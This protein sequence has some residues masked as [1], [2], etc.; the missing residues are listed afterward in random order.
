[1]AMEALAH[2][3]SLVE[4]SYDALLDA[5]CA[6]ELRPGE[7]IGQDEIAERLGVSR[8]P[9]NSAIAM[10]K[11]QRFVVD[12]GRRGVVVAPVDPLLFKAI[13]QV[14]AALD[15]LATELATPRLDA[16]AIRRGR[17]IVARG[18]ALMLAGNAKGVLQA[19]IDFHT[20]IYELSGNPVILDTMRLNWLHLRRTMGEVLRFPGMTAQVWKQH[21]E[22]WNAMVRQN[23]VE[24]ADLMRDHVVQAVE[25]V[26]PP[27]AA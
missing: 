16:T 8:Q 9:V 19:D 6:G 10:L 14:R 2:S 7:R 1:M 18:Q 5:I 11:A 15:P 27:Q 25:R 12:T 4:R 20:L 21:G 17:S 26:G 23:A 22:I 13:Y 24:A 3:R